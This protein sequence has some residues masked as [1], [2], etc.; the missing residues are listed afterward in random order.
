VLEQLAG[1]HAHTPEERGASRQDAIEEELGD[2]LFAVVNLCRK[3]GV[4]A[5]LALDR[6][7]A[8]F[9]RRFEGIEALA[10]A[11]GRDLREMTLEEMDRLW[12]ETKRGE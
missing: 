5:G 10:R 9:V 7:N 4:H 2:L 12:D 8:K 6:A 3:A 1:T 11:T